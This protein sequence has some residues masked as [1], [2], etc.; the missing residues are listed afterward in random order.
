MLMES[1]QKCAG[2]INSISS[3]V[4][5]DEL[6]ALRNETQLCDMGQVMLGAADLGEESTFSAQFFYPSELL[7]SNVVTNQIL[8]WYNQHYC[9][10]CHMEMAAF[11]WSHPAHVFRLKSHGLPMD[12]LTSFRCR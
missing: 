7:F 1:L 5:W 6:G 10:G 11:V 8:S 9:L 2:S 4:R 12:N 3:D